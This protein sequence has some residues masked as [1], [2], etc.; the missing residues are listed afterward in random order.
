MSHDTDQASALLAK[1]AS[2]TGAVSAEPVK[3]ALV[4]LG[5]GDGL[6]VPITA[7]VVEAP[8]QLVETSEI[9]LLPPDAPSRMTPAEEEAAPKAKRGRKAKVEL[10]SSS[11]KYTFHVDRLFDAGP[12][13]IE[14]Y[15]ETKQEEG[16]EFIGFYSGLYPM[17]R[18]PAV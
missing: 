17:F 4:K 8:A 15:L 7:P 18:R 6:V 13:D 12:D 11:V 5:G 16:W 1:L 10:V 14:G 9:A 2:L 3:P